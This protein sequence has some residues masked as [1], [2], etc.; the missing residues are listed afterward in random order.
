VPVAGDAR[1]YR[2]RVTPK[3]ARVMRQG[4]RRRVKALAASLRALPAADLVTLD[5][6]A[7]V[8]QRLLDEG[9]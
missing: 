5:A 8:L 4:R 1:S 6:A 2:V 3:G 9:R 7:D